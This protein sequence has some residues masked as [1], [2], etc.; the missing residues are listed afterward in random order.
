[1]LIST[2]YKNKDNSKERINLLLN[3]LKEGNLAEIE[4]FIQ[5]INL[6][7]DLKH[8]LFKQELIFKHISEIKLFE[9]KNQIFNSLI[10]TF[11]ES[12]QMHTNM[13]GQSNYVDNLKIFKNKVGYHKALNFYDQANNVFL[14]FYQKSVTDFYI[15]KSLY[16]QSLEFY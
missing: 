7:N 8:P 5:N 3:N 14:E 4:K 15:N 2:R 9:D 13:P 10:Q 16:Q 6:K 12:I 11:E 1:M